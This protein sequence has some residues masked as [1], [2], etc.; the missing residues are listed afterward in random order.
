MG[1]HYDLIQNVNMSIVPCLD[2]VA[3]L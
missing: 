2:K 1:F 3:V